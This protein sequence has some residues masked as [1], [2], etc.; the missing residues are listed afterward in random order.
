M[1]AT[2]ARRYIFKLAANF[3]SVPVYLLMEAILP[4]ALGPSVYGNFNFA[5]ALFQQI[6]GFLDMGTST[7]FYN[8][9][10]RHQL[11][12]SLFSFYLRVALAVL[13]LIML[14]AAI[15]LLPQVGELLMPDVP[16]YFAPL[17][18]LWAYLTWAGRVLRSA[19]DALGATIPSELWRAAISI[20]GVLLL[21]LL[22]MGDLLSVGMLFLQQYLLLGLSCLAF[23]HVCKNSWLQKDKILHWRLPR[24]KRKFFEAEFF[25]YSHPLFVQ[26]LLSFFM[27]TAERW[28]LQWFDGSTQQGFYAL[29]QKISMACFLFVSA[30]TPLLMREFSIAWG[31]KNIAVMGGLL[32]RFAPMLYILAAYFSCFT[33]AEGKTIV[34]FF[35]GSQFLAAITPVQIMALYPVHQ[36][37]GQMASSIF[38]A[39]GK[40]RILRNMAAAECFYGLLV[41]WLLIA[42]AHLGGLNLGAT[43]LAVKT[44]AVQF[45]SVNIYLWLASRFIPFAFGKNL[46]HQIWSVLLFLAF[47]YA[48]RELSMHFWPA[49]AW[50]RFF[51]SGAIYSFLCLVVCLSWPGCLGLSHDELRELALRF[52]LFIKKSLGRDFF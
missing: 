25:S 28:L 32:N 15:F 11:R 33:L 34:E 30:M 8:S 10:S 22:F 23:W 19:N 18:A 37:Y 4:R 39:S 42:P 43:G 40:T 3:A 20:F 47:A 7:C 5:T 13:L 27:L 2:L 21:L 51:A 48:C 26:S 45:V 49:A 17:A 31:K 50:L 12:T 24:M 46:F 1:A 16:L 44:V 35:G 14:L 52:K 6:T 41:T 38:H 29:S 36:A 9:L